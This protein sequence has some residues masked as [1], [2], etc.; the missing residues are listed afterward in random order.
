MFLR[1]VLN[2]VVLN[3]WRGSVFVFRLDRMPFLLEIDRS[4]QSTT[5]MQTSTNT[6]CNWPK[7]TRKLRAALQNGFNKGVALTLI[8]SFMSLSTPAASE[9]VTTG[10]QNWWE[11]TRF[12]LLSSRFAID[13]PNWFVG[14]LVPSGSTDQERLQPIAAIKIVPGD[15]RLQKGQE[16]SFS[17][18]GL[19]TNNEPMAGIDFQ[20]AV[21]DAVTGR[22]W[23][24]FSNSVFKATK[25]GTFNVVA[26]A[27]GVEGLARVVV[28]PQTGIRPKGTANRSTS[29]RTGLGDII[30]SEG[31][32]QNTSNGNNAKAETFDAPEESPTASL[33]HDDNWTS[34]DDPGNQTGNPPGN[35]VDGGAGSGNFQISAPVLSVPGR[36][37]DLALSLNYNSRVWN[38][39]GNELAYNVGYDEPA[40][41]WSLG[42]GKLEFMGQNGGCLMVDADG[43]RH[44]YTG[45]VSSWSTGSTFIGHTTDG[46]FIDY[47]CSI[48]YGVGGYGWA[49]LPNGSQVSYS[50]TNSYETHFQAVNI[51]DAQGNFVTITY[52]GST[53]ALIQTMTDTLGRVFTFHYDSLNRLIYIKA[54][55]MADQ[56]PSYGSD[57]TRVVV[58]LH[59]KPLTLSYSFGS[60][61]T[62]VVRPGTI[63]GLDAIYYPATNTG[64][65]FG[66]SDS[67][68]SYGMITKVI[69]QRGMSWSAGP[70]EQGTVTQGT[71]TKQADY[72]YP[73]TTANVTGRTNGIGL[74]DAPT[75]ETLAESWAGA[76][77]AGPAITTYKINQASSPRTT[78]V[79]Q[80]NG[81]VSRQYAY[82]NPAQ[83]ND[84]LVYSDESY[85][86]DATGTATIP[87][88]AG[89]FK[90]VGKSNVTWSAGNAA[91][92]DSPRPTEAEVFDE[93][94]HKLKTVYT[95]G[96][97]KFNQITKSCDYDNSNSLLKCANAAYENDVSYIGTYHGTTGQWQAGNH[98]F[99]LIKSTTLENP[100]GTKVSRTDY[101]YDNYPAQ[102]F[103]NTPG[104][105]QHNY[106]YNEFT[107]EQVYGSCL[108]YGPPYQCGDPYENTYCQDCEEWEM[109]SAYDPS[110]EKRGNL[111][112]STVY[113]DAQNATGQIDELRSYDITGNIVKVSS[114]CCEQTTTLY[115]DPSTPAID[116]FYAYPF[117]QTRGA[118]S[119]SSP[120]RITTSQVADFKTGL[121]KSATDANGRTSTR[122]YNPDTLR[123]DRS[124]L[125]TGAYTLHSFDDTAMTFAE[126]AKESDGTLAGKTIKYLNGV[127]QL[128]KEESSSVSFV[129]IVE[130][131]YTLFGE[132]WMQSRPYRSGDPVQWSE[133]FYDAQR[134]LVKVVE[135]DGSETKA[136][137][138]EVTLPNSVSSMP[139]NRLRIM[140]AWG[141]DRWGRYDQQ[142]RL[143]QV[144]EPN[145]DAVA[146]PTGSV[147]SSGSLLTTFTYDTQERLVE[148]EQGSQ[149]RRFRYDDLGRLTRQKLAE[150]TA[151]LNDNGDYVGQGGSG[152]NWSSAYYYDNRSNLIQK[153]DA[154]GVKALYSFYLPGGAGLDPLNRLQWSG[155][156]LTGPLDTSSP[157]FASQP[158]TYAYI[159]SG[160]KTRIDTI[161]T[162]AI[163]EEEFTYD[164][165]GR[166]SENTKTVAFRPSHPF[167]TS[168][169]YDSLDR[170]TEV[171][172]PA[173][174]GLTGSP[175]KI[176][177]NSYDTASRLSGMTV[178]GQ[179][180]VS[181]IVYDATDQTT[182][183][184]V[185]TAGTNQITEEYTFDLQTGLLA[186]QK[187]T[188][189]KGVVGESTLLDLSYQ[190][191]RGGSAG[192]LTGKTGHLTKTVDNLDP[193]KNRVYDFDALGRLI[194]A[195]GGPTFKRWDQEYT[196]DR[197]GN[198]TNVVASGVA[199]DN[200][201]IPIDGLPNLTYDNATNRITTS[202]FQYDVNGNQIRAL[203]E[204]G[205][206][207]IKYEYDSA[208]RLRRVRKD[209]VGQTLLQEFEYAADNARLLSHNAQAN[210]YSIYA[211]VGGTVLAEYTEFV[212]NTPAWVK[213]YT[214]L[215]DSQLSTITPNGSGGETTEYNHPDRLGTR[216][217]TN[218]VS[219][220]SSEQA[221][222]PFGTALNAESSV[223]NNNKRFTTYDRSSITK[224][225][226]AVNRTY[227]SKLG[228]FTQVDPIGMGSVS[229]SLPQTLNLYAYC[230]NDPINYVDPSGLGFFSFLKKLF[231]WALMVVAV[232]VAVISVIGILAATTVTL[233]MILGTVAAVA[234]AASQ[235]LGLLGFST[236]AK[237]LGWIAIAAGIGAGLIATKGS[238]S[239][240]IKDFTQRLDQPLLSWQNIADT[241]SIGAYH[242]AFAS[243]PRKKETA[244]QRRKRLIRSSINS[245]LW[246]LS[247]MPGCKDFIQ[248]DSRHD[249]IASLESL[250]ANNGVVYD[251][252][253]KI[254][255][256]VSGSDL[257]KGPNSKIRLGDTWFEDGVGNWKGTMNTPRTQTNI[258][259]HGL[260][261]AVEGR[262]HPPGE[263]NNHYYN[264]IAKKCFGINP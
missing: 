60:G 204:D 114:T 136:Y 69:E 44:G 144:V 185:G 65:W 89:T 55:R 23:H 251:S 10:A 126:E 238:L 93:N 207:W 94:G 151:T 9:T 109:V 7:S 72:N 181:G 201:P 96:T 219:G 54:P 5:Y 205:V 128:R 232:I 80:P 165:E 49:R 139:G 184:K 160:D 121:I 228:R 18:I 224:L 166:V 120:H 187:A 56:D 105:I 215:G 81:A 17:A 149:I 115:D 256:Q 161:S 163:L 250:R 209:D 117:S 13:L 2:F 196:Y 123:P 50:T 119:P 58:R 67:Y 203:A 208:N 24:G 140:D 162:N 170:I 97:G 4:T 217:I 150:Q 95:Y 28:T 237:I 154:R 129:D 195:K 221:H 104:V 229:L 113:S 138:N 261:H 8:F 125:S 40:P 158:T 167:V 213:S 83:Y 20:W 71:M 100:S 131:K 14:A 191:D 159:T 26:K 62:P 177:A 189:N 37:I 6:F 248:K 223:T 137:Y 33:W 247:N 216:T 3:Y 15:V 186:N 241:S 244:E 254:P 19:D 16:A 110:T 211:S 262:N 124:T 79:I 133:K 212:A 42:F 206:N 122:G 127:G 130:T 98:V 230:A 258:L 70:D 234:S 30:S 51:T 168:Y 239:L 63:Y 21:V 169:L 12:S 118:A 22:S 242:N 132:E 236:A 59:Y 152:A 111:T 157:I 39:A 210:Q 155:Y 235:V 145:P 36:G 41:G 227:D 143:A 148:T 45:T 156:D 116:S 141:R 134:R 153:N 225:D 75:Y 84:G 87:G 82:N 91:N 183:M 260:K 231:K 202:G 35:P 27:R 76:D 252:S 172:Y 106:F 178:G 179:T 263:A 43:T 192:S 102:P 53:N 253:L 233:A 135:P 31:T 46:S 48:T 243:K 57:T 101:E 245:A 73:L 220:T 34:F 222:L 174:Y 190:Y 199:A 146:N 88:V 90:L 107:T 92:Y 188:K 240:M 194:R 47:G 255:E 249:A 142:G 180:A 86:P 171:Q 108:V 78:T 66:D 214:Y 85:V 193:N 173:Q 38:K 52:A 11:A 112:K 25:I 99:N 246:R 1:S 182:Q 147:F 259:L 257:G 61:I 198:R 68:S 197:Y 226:Y 77:V 218:Q 64:Y 175:R 29:S 200:S 74:T 264:E 32:T 103:T 176:V 164:V